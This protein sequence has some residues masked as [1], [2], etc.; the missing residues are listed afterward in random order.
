MKE[1]TLKVHGMTCGH[2]AHTILNGLSKIGVSAIVDVVA[3]SVMVQTGD[4]AAALEAVVE[5]IEQKGYY[6]EK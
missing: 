5:T 3:G 6:V 2:Y 4:D 1:T